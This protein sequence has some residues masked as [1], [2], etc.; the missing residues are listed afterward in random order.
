MKKWENYPLGDQEPDFD[1]EEGSYIVGANSVLRVSFRN[2]A[3]TEGGNR[4]GVKEFHALREELEEGASRAEWVTTNDISDI[5]RV[6]CM[7]AGFKEWDIE[8]TGA[9]L[10]QRIVANP[11]EAYLDVIKTVAEGIGF[12]FY[13]ADPKPDGEP[14]DSIGVPTFRKSRV[15]SDDTEAEL[16]ALR[17]G[18]PG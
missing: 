6:I 13:M 2:L 7:W 14:I 12:N 4:A 16:K 1:P 11:G 18:H 10:P 3:A 15:I 17:E 5:V 8:D 9:R